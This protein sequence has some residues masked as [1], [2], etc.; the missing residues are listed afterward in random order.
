MSP[1]E[2]LA[3]SV[4][5]IK[6]AAEEIAEATKGKTVHV[7]TVHRWIFKGVRGH[8]LNAC[9]IGCSW[10]TSREEVTRFINRLSRIDA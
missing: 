4:M 2:L 6:Q 8:R 1:A 3:E 5:T 9:R 7:S 10:V